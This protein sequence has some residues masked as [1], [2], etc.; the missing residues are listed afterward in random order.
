MG[1]IM[2]KLFFYFKSILLLLLYLIIVSTINTI[3]YLYTNMSYSLNCLILFVFTTLGFFIVNFINGQKA[4]NKGYL[5]G[6][7]L[8]SVAIGIF[9]LI[10]L[11]SK[12]FL[13]FSKVIYY[14]VLIL[15]STISAAIG[16][17]F[18]KNTNSK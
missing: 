12:E 5:E 7:K 6:L 9:F 15:T 1:D 17:N 14:L 2:N 16:I 11:F 4:T 8:G 13:S 18:K 10:S 3:F